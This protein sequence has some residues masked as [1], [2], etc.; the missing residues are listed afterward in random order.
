MSGIGEKMSKI[1][2]ESGYESIPSLAKGFPIKVRKYSNPGKL[3]PHWHEHMELLYFTA[4]ECNLF[5]GGRP[6]SIREGDIVAVNGGE[7]HSFT[8]GGKTEY[9]CVLIYPDFFRDVEFSSFMIENV[10]RGD[11]EARGY[12]TE[13]LH[14]YEQGGVASDMMQK[15]L[16]YRLMS[17]LVREHSREP[18]SDKSRERR[19]ATLTRLDRVFDT[20]AERYRDKL[21]TRDLAEVCY[22]SEAHFCRFFKAATGKTALEYLNEYRI[23]RAEALLEGTDMALSEIAES[24]G[25]EDVNYFCRLYRRIKGTSPAAS[26]AKG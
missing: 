22:L 10:I 11:G 2:S 9:V 25:L 1:N 16:A 5:V 4:G 17:H 14:E 7:I 18:L 3:T 6:H 13:M 20:V 15:S 26:R 23:S 24:V 19:Q 12:I 8:S 21:S